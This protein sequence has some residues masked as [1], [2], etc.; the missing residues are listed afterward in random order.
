MSTSTPTP[1]SES[2][3]SQSSQNNQDNNS[4]SLSQT[5]YIQHTLD[6]FGRLSK[7]ITINNIDYLI[8]FICHKP[9]QNIYT[10][11]FSNE[12]DQL[13]YQKE[14]SLDSLIKEKKKYAV[15]D[16]EI[17]L[18]IFLAE[19]LD[20]NK[21]NFVFADNFLFLNVQHSFSQ[22]MSVDYSLKLESKKYDSDQILSNLVENFK[23]T[24]NRMSELNKTKEMQDLLQKD[25][26]SFKNIMETDQKEEEKEVCNLNRNLSQLSDKLNIYVEKVGL[27]SKEIKSLEMSI[28]QKET[29]FETR[30]AEEQTKD[31]IFINNRKTLMSNN[32]E[33]C[34]YANSFLLEDKLPENGCAEIQFKIDRKPEG[35]EDNFKISFGFVVGGIYKDPVESYYKQNDC[36]AIGFEEGKVK[37][38][39]NDEEDAGKLCEYLPCEGDILSLCIDMDNSYFYT[40]LNGGKYTLKRKM[41]NLDKT[42]KSNLYAFIDMSTEDYQ[43]S[44]V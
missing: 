19:Q 17:K 1:I 5:T 44:L 14:F 33:S 15:F 42:K 38:S 4:S 43:I 40:K 25:F 31:F 39:Q 3:N 32:N 27:L 35:K 24:K 34:G 16:D 36:W 2:Q 28:E 22:T 11:E 13:F 10:I 41:H 12:F 23:I 9:Q 37:N 8:S 26:T 21:I 30:F 7:Q 29:I 18:I 6:S 20:Q